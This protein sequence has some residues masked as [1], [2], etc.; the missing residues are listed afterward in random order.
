MRETRSRRWNACVV[1]SSR[2]DYGLLVWVMRALARARHFRLQIVATGMHLSPEFGHTVDVV[3]A[4]GFRID[5]KVE[6]LLSSDTALGVA[7]SVGLGTIGL[8]E[9]LAGLAPDCVLVLG[10]RFETF[11]A[12]QAAF[13]LSIPI[14]HLAGGDETAGAFDDALRHAMTKMAHVHFVTNKEAARRVRQMGEDPGRIF[15]YGSP[16]LDYVR[17]LRPLSRKTLAARLDFPFRER[18]LLVTF[19]PV[20]RGTRGSEAELAALLSALDTFGSSCGMIFTKPN[21]DTDGRRLGAMVDEYVAARPHCRAY[22]S[23]GPELYLNLLRHVDAVVGNSSS[24]LYEAPSFG[25]PTVNVG[26]RQAGRLRAASVFDT[27]GDAGAIAK[28]ITR[29]LR[30]DCSKTVNP[31]GDGRSASRIVATLAKLMPRLGSMQ[32]PFQWT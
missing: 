21:A 17:H 27:P 26:D 25:I 4:D 7:K 29:A 13:F 8:A 19:H 32:K 24:G 22:T 11:A 31:Y 2:A 5:R 12:A 9:A 18:N 16:G 14:V 20:T 23:L 1:T 3:E 28:T 30:A 15:N 10:D 6:M